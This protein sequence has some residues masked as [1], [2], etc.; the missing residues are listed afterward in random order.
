MR[1]NLRCKRCGEFT[2]RGLYKACSHKCR[3][4][5][6]LPKLTRELIEKTFREAFR[7]DSKPQEIKLM[8]GLDGH[9]LIKDTWQKILSLPPA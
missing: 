1:H 4:R 9:N 3:N 7:M 5:P 6:I 8:M 2:G